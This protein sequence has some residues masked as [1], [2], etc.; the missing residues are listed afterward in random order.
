MT[1]IVVM[2]ILVL[3][4]AHIIYFITIAPHLTPQVIILLSRQVQ[5]TLELL[6]SPTTSGHAPTRLTTVDHEMCAKHFPCMTV[7]DV[8]IQHTA[9]KVQGVFL[10]QLAAYAVNDDMEIIVKMPGE[11]IGRASVLGS[12][13]MRSAEW[14]LRC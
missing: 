1:L 5:L 4:L 7:G 9:T 8:L 10:A 13:Y 2:T 12:Q 11:G 14:L 3:P 6:H